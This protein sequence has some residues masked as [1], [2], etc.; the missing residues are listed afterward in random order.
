MTPIVFMD[1][2]ADGCLETTEL[3]AKADTVKFENVQLVQ[4]AIESLGTADAAGMST[5][6]AGEGGRDYKV[7]V[8]DKDGK[9]APKGTLVYVT[10]ADADLEGNVY[11]QR[12]ATN[13][14]N[15]KF[16]GENVTTLTTNKDGVASFTLIGDKLAYATPTV[17]VDNGTKYNELDKSDAQTSGKIVY[18]GEAIVSGASVKVKNSNDPV[19]TVESVKAGE[20]A[21]FEYQVVDQNGKAYR[22]GTHNATFEVFNTGYNTI[23]ANGIEIKPFKNASV[24]FTAVAGKAIMNVTSTGVTSVS[25]N[26]SGSQY[27]LGNQ[28]AAVS[29]T[30]AK[31]LTDGVAYT[32]NCKICKQR[33]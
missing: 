15:F 4:V 26:V 27:T 7:T 28:T 11:L 29:F 25:V 30:D 10:V 5:I 17:F 31:L 14:G 19:T 3:Q 23:I 24:P 33:R 6:G 9:L 8:T 20:T 2:I 22:T 16:D 18:F 13:G 21:V 1:T 32:W 12:T